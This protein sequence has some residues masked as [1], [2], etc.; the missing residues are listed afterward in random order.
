M[1][2]PVSRLRKAD[3][4]WLAKHRCKHGHTYLEH[5][6]CFVTEKPLTKRV[7]YID[8]ET[9]DFKADW[10]IMLCYVIE[11][12]EGKLYENRIMVDDMRNKHI[13][14]YHVVKSC[15]EDM[16]NFD[17]LIGYYHSN[18][19]LPFIRTRAV[20]QKIKFPHYEEIKQKDV[21]YMIR[22]RFRL[23]S[24]RL[25]NACKALLGKSDKTKMDRNVW[26]AASVCGDERA[27]DYILEHCRYD[28][29][30]VKKLYHK[31]IDYSKPMEKSI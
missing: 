13:M 3:I 16:K 9:T 31:V 17:I 2:A 15:V 11:S 6:Q 29:S 26:R 18:F 23:T 4:I 7:G 14:D 28:V 25:E 19:D 21:Y 30:D 22:N 27:L 20:T 24:N 10:G 8:I 1:L 5:Y 12:E